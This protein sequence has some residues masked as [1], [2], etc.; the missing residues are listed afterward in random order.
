MNQDPGILFTLFKG[1]IFLTDEELCFKEVYDHMCIF[2]DYSKEELLQHSLYDLVVDEDKKLQIRQLMQVSQKIIDL[3]ITL[4]T[5][6]NQ[7]VHCILSLMAFE[8]SNQKKIFQGFLQEMTYPSKKNIDALHVEKLK[9]AERLINTLAHEVRNPLN[10][11]NLSVEQLSSELQEENTVVFLD[12]IKRNSERIN[13][14]INELLNATKSTELVL[15]KITLQDVIQ[16]TIELVNKKIDRNNIQFEIDLSPKAAYIKG[17][18]AKLA[19]AF[20]NIII[21]AAEAIEQ[22][23]GK[24]SIRL[25]SKDHEHS[26]QVNDN[27]CGISADNFDKLFEPYFSTKNKRLGL[28]LTYALNIIHAHNGTLNVQSTPKK[29]TTII[30]SFTQIPV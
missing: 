16:K 15:D 11:M 10:N 22:D 1:S 8:N 26:I 14:I 3:E 17:D 12:I 29:G 2:L 24:I 21:N 4:E 19:I 13:S 18:T 5:K 28:G 7:N 9:A 25:F 30:I 27:G 23:S 6:L 20:L